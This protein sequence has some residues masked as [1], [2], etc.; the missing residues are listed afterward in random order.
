[1]QDRAAQVLSFRGGHQEIPE[2]IRKRSS[3]QLE[4]LLNVQQRETLD[5]LMKLVSGNEAPGPKNPYLMTKLKKPNQELKVSKIGK[6]LRTSRL[7]KT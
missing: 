1:M 7:S 6:A 4:E 3:Y 5:N 2:L